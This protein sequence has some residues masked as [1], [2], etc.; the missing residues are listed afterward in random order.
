[1]V[2]LRGQ[3]CKWMHR[4][5][6]YE[7]VTNMGSCVRNDYAREHL[8]KHAFKHKYLQLFKHSDILKDGEEK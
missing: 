3:L 6:G 5:Y 4:I 2:D 1:V 7:T 8:A